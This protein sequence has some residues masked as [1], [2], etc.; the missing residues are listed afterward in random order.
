MY[1]RRVA[2]VLLD[3]CLVTLCY[4]A[5]Y[6]LRFEDPEE[7]MKNFHMFTHSLPMVVAAQLVAFFVVGVY[8]GVWRHFGMM[9]TL[10]D[11][12]RACSS[13]PAPRVLVDPVHLRF[14]HLL[15]DRVRYLCGA[16]AD[17]DDAVARLVPDRRQIHAAAAPGRHTVAIYGAGDAAGLVLRELLARHAEN[18]RIVGFV[19]DDPRKA[20]IRVMGYSVLGGTPRWRC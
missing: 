15:A 9:D 14:P 5:A 16:A 3:F 1:K 6:R 18:V 11:R 10:D 8:R 19:D 20:G 12:A 17:R 2:E 13:A 4:Y 7:F